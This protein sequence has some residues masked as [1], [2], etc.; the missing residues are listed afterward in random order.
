[1]D[2]KNTEKTMDQIVALC[3]GRGFVLSLIHI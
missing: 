1:M 3:K 2:M